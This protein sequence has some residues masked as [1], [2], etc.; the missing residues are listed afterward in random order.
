MF[1]ATKMWIEKNSSPLPVYHRRLIARRIYNSSTVF[2]IVMWATICFL[3]LIFLGHGIAAPLIRSD[4]SG[5]EVIQMALSLRSV[6]TVMAVISV[7]LVTATYTILIG[8]GG[9][10]ATTAMYP[11]EAVQADLGRILSA[12]WPDRAEHS[13]G[14]GE[15]SDRK[16]SEASTNTPFS[17]IFSSVSTKSTVGKPTPNSIRLFYLGR[18][19]TD[20][21]NGGVVAK[22]LKECR[23]EPFG[24]PAQRKLWLTSGSAL[25][26]NIVQILVWNGC[27][28]G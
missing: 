21:A 23:A 22:G 13:F 3:L 28:L 17:R 20:G 2:T 7:I 10:M 18:M 6:E 24:E 14:E 27:R 4:I 5:L 12:V 8:R 15:P 9:Y 11:A 1:S 16:M 25:N 19:D 26:K